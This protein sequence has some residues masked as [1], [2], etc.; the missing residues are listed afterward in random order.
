MSPFYNTHLQQ[1]QIRG[2]WDRSLVTKEDRGGWVGTY[3]K[4]KHVQPE[5]TD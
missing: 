1:T 5:G 3:E 2:L 4:V